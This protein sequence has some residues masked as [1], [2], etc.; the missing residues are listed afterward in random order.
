MH[1]TK[2]R[3]MNIVMLAA[4]VIFTLIVTLYAR[5]KDSSKI[6]IVEEGNSTAITEE[7]PMLTPVERNTVFLSYAEYEEEIKEPTTTEETTTVVETTVEETTVQETTTVVET[8]V[9]QETT[10]EETIAVV[11]ITNEEPSSVGGPLGS[12]TEDEVYL[13]AQILFCEVGG[14]NTT[15]MSYCGSVIINRARSNNRDFANVSSIREVLY[16]PGQYGIYTLSKIER[17]IQPTQENL[18]VARGLLNGT[19]ECLPEDILYQVSAG[20]NP[21]GNTEQVF[22]PGTTSESYFR[23][24]Q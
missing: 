22:L 13:L 10:A 17:G 6:V 21:G 5:S 11:E 8:T 19:I 3:W 9:Q 4:T 1:Q 23:I 7:R 20:C 15:E 12:Y 14:Q 18:D 2:M 16:Q 24:I